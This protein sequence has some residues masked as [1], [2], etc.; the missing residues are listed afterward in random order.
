MKKIFLFLFGASALFLMTHSFAAINSPSFLSGTYVQAEA[1]GSFSNSENVSPQND[2]TGWTRPNDDYSDKIG[3]S[4]LYGFGFGYRFNSL[5]RADITYSQRDNFKY[6]KTFYAADRCRTFDVKNKTL[7]ANVYFNFNGL[8]KDKPLMFDP[9]VG[10]GIGYAWNETDNFD[11]TFADG[12]PQIYAPFRQ[13]DERKH[14]NLAW[15]L[16]LGVTA[17]LLKHLDADLGYRYFNIGKITTGSM[18]G[19]NMGST[20]IDPLTA[21]ETDMQEIY[22]HIR[23]II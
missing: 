12:S 8:R 14:D 10:L 2:K 15:Q 9:F 20:I 23:Y 13:N 22:L 7:M 4:F 6:D 1:G 5:I 16:T 18:T 19:Q 21:S 11:A 3:N 17:H